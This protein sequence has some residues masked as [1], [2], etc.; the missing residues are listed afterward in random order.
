[1]AIWTPVKLSAS[2][3]GKFVQVAATSIGSGTTVHTADSAATDFINLWC[4]NTDTVSRDLTIGWG[5]TTSADTITQTIP[6]KSGL[7][8]VVLRLPLTNSLVVKAAGSVTNV[9]LVSGEVRRYS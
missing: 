7:V 6:A 2:T 3:D 4:T 5:G 9:L 1:M 8:A